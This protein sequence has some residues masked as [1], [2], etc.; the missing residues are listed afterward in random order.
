MQPARSQET[1]HSLEAM[2]QSQYGYTDTTQT[3]QSNST[4]NFINTSEDVV[5][6]LN[7]SIPKNSPGSIYQPYIRGAADFLR[8]QQLYAG[9]SARPPGNAD[10]FPH[11]DA[12]LG[13]LAK[14]L[15][16][17]MTNMQDT[18]E[19]G[20][21]SVARIYQ[22]APYE[23][24]LK[25]WE[26]LF[27][28]RD[29]QL[30]EVGLSRWGALFDGEDFGCFM[31][32]YHDVRTKMHFCKSLVSS[33]FDD[34]FTIRIALNPSGEFKKKISNMRNNTRRGQELANIRDDK[35]RRAED[36]AELQLQS[37]ADA[38]LAAGAFD[39]PEEELRG[40]LT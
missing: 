37:K 32:R 23:I 22:I 4:S 38:L 7:D 31:D 14:D 12:A 29:V 27:V 18:M 21:K 8:Q 34:E 20:K 1:T 2:A 35:K 16:D 5:A 3:M 6:L 33:L 39:L 24:I 15:A 19:A 9:L 17:A 28:I 11:D 26:L 10:D 36:E 25:A 13:V 40:F 30:G